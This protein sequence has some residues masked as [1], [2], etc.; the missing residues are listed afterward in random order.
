[1][2]AK[3]RL[4]DVTQITLHRPRHAFAFVNNHLS[5]KYTRVVDGQLARPPENNQIDL[6][7]VSH[8]G[9]LVGEHVS[10]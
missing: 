3:R 10:R 5:G 4:P 2:S 9:R 8:F 7:A 6:L 1:M